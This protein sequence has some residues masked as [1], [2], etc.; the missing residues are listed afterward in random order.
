MMP[1]DEPQDEGPPT[2]HTGE[3]QTMIKS[4]FKGKRAT[5]KFGQYGKRG[6]NKKLNYT[7]PQHETQQILSPSTGRTSTGR[8]LSTMMIIRKLSTVASN[9]LIQKEVALSENQALGKKL[10]KSK[11]VVED[12]RTC[13]KDARMGMR[14]TKLDLVNALKDNT[15]MQNDFLYRER[16][17]QSQIDALKKKADATLEQAKRGHKIATGKI[18]SKSESKLAAA[19]RKNTRVW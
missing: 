19:E 15:T 1:Q 12:L 3:G 5:K 9:A 13:L 18:L 2:V 10:S 6:G 14:S 17:H 8:K 11:V 4:G 16:Y 7:P